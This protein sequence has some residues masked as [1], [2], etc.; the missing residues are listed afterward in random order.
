MKDCICVTEYGKIQG[1]ERN[2][3]EVYLA[4]PYGGDVSGGRRFLAPQKPDRWDGVLDCTHFRH[5]AYQT[6]SVP[7]ELMPAGLRER[8]IGISAH[9]AGGHLDL[10]L[11]VRSLRTLKEDLKDEDGAID[12]TD[13]RLPFM[14]KRLLNITNLARR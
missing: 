10:G 14:I 1:Y 7:P 3:Q 12:D 13:I 9:F 5:K 11:G 2:G 4:V 8:M 6:P